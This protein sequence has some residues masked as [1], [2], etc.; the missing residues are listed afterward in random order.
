MPSLTNPFGAPSSGFVGAGV[1][2]IVEDLEDPSAMGRV[3]V[4]FPHLQDE[5][6]SWWLR[7]A[8][9]HGGKEQGIW[10][11]P[12]KGDE[13][14]VMFLQ[15]SQDEGI[16]IATLY[17]GKDKP[18]K[19]AY[20]TLPADPGGPTGWA[21]GW[22]AAGESKHH[23]DGKLNR[24]LWRSREGHLF[25]MDDSAGK[26]SMVLFDKGRK[27]AMAF[28]TV[29]G[30]IYIASGDTDVVIRAAKNI[31]IEATENIKMKAGKSI[32]IE[33]GKDS[34]WKTGTDWKVDAGT[35]IDMKAAT[36]SKQEA[37]ANLEA[38]AGAAMKL[39]G[40]ATFEAKGGGTAKVEAGAVLTLKGAMVAIN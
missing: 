24:F 18:P 10:S 19:E 21:G 5:L 11:I 38:K 37:G 29:K 28:D 12:D 23:A 14:L 9:P 35:N 3:R 31:L 26:E 20:S 15:G 6:K 32:E 39:E 4:K 40:S 8:T 25:M 22:P 17:N 7:V 1:I 27:L 16:V 2:G 34:K 36:N 13:V 30:K 33:S